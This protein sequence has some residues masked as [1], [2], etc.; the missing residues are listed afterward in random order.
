MLI[1]TCP[2]VKTL[3]LVLKFCDFYGRCL[4]AFM[5]EFH[6]KI[7]WIWMPEFLTSVGSIINI[8]SISP[9]ILHFISSQIDTM[10]SKKLKT[11]L[12]ITTIQ[13]R[14]SKNYTEYHKARTLQ[15]CKWL[16]A[17]LPCQA[18]LLLSNYVISIHYLI[19]SIQIK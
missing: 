12:L 17:H 6:N 7:N 8:N 10:K 1:W 15:W 13:S 9:I 14:D 16:N 2:L 3:L 19:H 18:Q 5:C 4:F 11:V